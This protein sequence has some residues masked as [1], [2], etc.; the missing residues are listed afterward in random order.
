MILLN[1]EVRED[2]V[3]DIAI[4]THMRHRKKSMVRLMYL[5]CTYT[6]IS[7]GRR[8]IRRN[9]TMFVWGSITR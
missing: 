1:I 6:Q 7:V 8:I 4:V 2:R 3:I 5:Y 9:G